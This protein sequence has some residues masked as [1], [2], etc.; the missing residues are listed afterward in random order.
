MSKPTIVG[1][2]PWLPQ[3]LTQYRW[4]TEPVRAERLAA[5]R[6]G[7]G[8]VLLIDILGTYLPQAR[9]FFGRGSLGSPDVFVGGTHTWWRWS[10]LRNIEDP[11]ALQALLGVWAVVAAFLLLGILPRVSAA[12]AWLLS[13][14][15][16][17]LNYY[18]H[19]S[20]DNVRTIALFYLALSP[21]GAVWSVTGKPSRAAGDVGVPAWPVRLLFLQLVLIYFLNGVYKFTGPDWRDGSMMHHVIGSVAWTRFSADDL[22]LPY[23][24]LQ[25]LTW[26]TL[27][28]ELG[29]PLFVLIPSTRKLVL[30]V[31]FLFHVGTA[32][33]LQIGVFPLYMM[34]L[35]LP[36]V[37]WERYVEGVRRAR[38][39]APSRS[40]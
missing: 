25:I 38:C 15:F 17:G 9:D 11:R 14:S 22:P 23:P 27:V 12:A 7:V 13:I 33:H 1:T 24:A 18:L 2:T 30:C 20:G 36:L 4:W 35:Y 40:N 39:A 28:F 31:A 26:V 37:P 6:I 19:N 3:F 34:A 16:I 32:V 21:C 10:L 5:F 8:L 29:F